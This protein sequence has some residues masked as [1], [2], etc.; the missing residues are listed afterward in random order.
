MEEIEKTCGYASLVNSSCTKCGKE[1]TPSDFV[2]SLSL[3][4][5][6]FLNLLTY[7][8]LQQMCAFQQHLFFS[9]LA[10]METILLLR[11]QSAKLG[12]ELSFGSSFC[13]CCAISILDE[14]A[15][16]FIYFF[17][18]VSLSGLMQERQAYPAP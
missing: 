12:P 2:I 9:P 10:R 15:S 3:L 17:H 13:D 6:V 18:F 5:S 16:P 4:L 14:M 11:V 1:T 8:F 7:V